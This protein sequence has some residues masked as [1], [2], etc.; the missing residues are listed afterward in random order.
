MLDNRRRAYA[1]RL[2][3]V[4]AKASDGRSRRRWSR[5]R[6]AVAGEVERAERD[7]DAAAFANPKDRELLDRLAG[8]Q[9]GLK[10][11]RHRCRR[12]SAAR[13]RARLAA[14][15]LTWRLAQ[16]YPARVCGKRRRT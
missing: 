5:R 4:R 16:E 12:R 6:D 1:E 9:D 14:G 10:V 8:V 7:Q 13:E 11:A 3:Q 15:A 2:P